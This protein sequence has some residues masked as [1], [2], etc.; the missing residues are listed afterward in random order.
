VVVGVLKVLLLL[1][2]LLLLMVVVVV[3]GLAIVH[4]HSKMRITVMM[5]MMLV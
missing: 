1:L 2:L 5:V 4:R 3:N